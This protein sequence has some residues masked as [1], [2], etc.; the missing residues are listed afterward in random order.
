MSSPSSSDE[1]QQIEQQP[2][3]KTRTAATT[4]PNDNDVIIN[5]KPLLNIAKE[6]GF[7]IEQ[8]KDMEQDL[9]I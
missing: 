5:L 9:L 4:N 6:K 7:E 2:Q 3:T 1:E 8:N